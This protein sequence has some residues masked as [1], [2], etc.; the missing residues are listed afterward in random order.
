MLASPI[1]SQSA[2]FICISLTQTL[3]LDSNDAQTGGEV[4]K[5]QKFL[6][7]DPSIYPEGVVNGYYDISLVRAVQRYQSTYGIV[8]SGSPA[9]TGWGVVGS[10]TRA[11]LLNCNAQKPSPSIK[12]KPVGYAASPAKPLVAPYPES[13]PRAKPRMYSPT[14]EGCPS[15]S[16]TL[17]RGL[18]GQDVANLQFFF[19]EHSYFEGNPTGF[20]GS[21]TEDAVKSFQSAQ[22]IVSS[23]SPAST[24][25]G[26][27]GPRTR[28]AV[29]AVCGNPPEKEQPKEEVVESEAETPP[30]EEVVESEAEEPPKE[31]VVE[32]E[33]DSTYPSCETS[34]SPETVTVG[35]KATLNWSTTNAASVTLSGMG[36]VEQSGMLEFFPYESINFTLNVIGTSGKETQCV[37]YIEVYPVP[38]PELILTAEPEGI[39][40]GGSATITW[41]A[42]GV[43]SCITQ[44]GGLAVSEMSGSFSTGPLTASTT[45]TLECTSVAGERTAEVTVQ[46]YETEALRGLLR[47]MASAYAALGAWLNSF[48]SLSNVGW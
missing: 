12:T 48:L 44:G 19:K 26:V 29:L 37:Q 15:F 17:Q 43:A 9:T 30:E 25:Y 34:V 16:R 33:V 41:S 18:E 10:S 5:L 4:S 2:T 40:S 1:L 7:Q 39:T 21:I 46:V 32:D 27:V 6:A 47:N 3:A 23:G 11:A 45:Y 14:Y 24:G 31:E 42:T 20:F 13:I 8:S 28:S 35:E 36:K 38:E 22:G